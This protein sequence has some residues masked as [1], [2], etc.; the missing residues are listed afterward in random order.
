MQL[1]NYVRAFLTKRSGCFTFKSKNY[2]SQIYSLSKV[3]RIDF[4]Y[5]ALLSASK[6]ELYFVVLH[7]DV[8]KYEFLSA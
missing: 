8:K 4:I 3:V 6:T 2:R 1:F 7:T 5:C